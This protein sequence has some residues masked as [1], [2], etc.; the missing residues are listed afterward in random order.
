MKRFFWVGL[1]SLWAVSSAVH[2]QDTLHFVF[3]NT[4][5]N[6]EVLS[7]E[8]AS[9]LQ[10]RHLNNIGRLYQ[11]NKILAAGPFADGGGFF[12]VNATDSTELDSLLQSDAAIR[13][14]R[15]VLETH[16][17]S[18]LHG[19]LCK[20]AEPFAKGTVAFIRIDPPGAGGKAD[21][22]TL[23]PSMLSEGEAM[24]IG[25]WNDGG[26]FVIGRSNNPVFSEWLIRLKRHG[27]RS[28]TLHRRT[29]WYGKGTFCE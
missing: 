26:G 5:P 4:N 9:A 28:A 24:M 1:I 8:A 16:P 22:T 17:L 7:K 19:K 29:L 23:P 11:K 25:S 20:A 3:L 10:Q 2:A 15:F 13:A 6:R 18:V 14:N 27:L 21:L 12:I